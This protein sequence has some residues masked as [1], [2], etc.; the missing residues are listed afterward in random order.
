MNSSSVTL[1]SSPLARTR[2]ETAFG[3][4]FL[5]AEDEDEG[6]FLEAEVSDF[7][8]HL[9]AGGVEFYAEACGF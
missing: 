2:T 6:D 1:P 5:V 3:G 9:A 4:G 7:A 8:L